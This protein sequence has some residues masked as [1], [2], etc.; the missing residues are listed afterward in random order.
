MVAALLRTVFTQD[1]PA[2]CHQQQRLVADQLRDK[3]PKIAALMEGCEDEV[4]VHM[5]SQGAPKAVAQ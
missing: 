2:G 5:V 1:S 3:V 4:V